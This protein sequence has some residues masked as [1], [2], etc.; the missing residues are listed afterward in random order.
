MRRALLF[1]WLFLFLT[2]PVF[3]EPSSLTVTAGAPTCQ[4]AWDARYAAKVGLPHVHSLYSNALTEKLDPDH[5]GSEQPLTLMTEATADW[6]GITDHDLKLDRGRWGILER[7]ASQFR[8][9]AKVLLLGIECTYFGAFDPRVNHVTLYGVEQLVGVPN[10]MAD[11]QGIAC[12][13]LE[14]L[15]LWL[16]TAKT[17]AVAIIAHPW[18]GDSHCNNMRPNLIGAG[19]E[20]TVGVEIGGGNDRRT[21]FSLNHGEQYFLQGLQNGLWL[22]P[23]FGH[24]NMTD[25]WLHKPHAKIPTVIWTDRSRPFSAQSL[26]EA[27]RAR[28]FYTRLSGQIIQFLGHGRTDWQPMGGVVALPQNQPLRL[29]FAITSQT[30]LTRLE[31]VQVGWGGTTITK[32]PLPTVTVAAHSLRKDFRYA[33]TIAITANSSLRCAYLRLWSG[34]QLE[35]VTAPIWITW[36]QAI[37]TAPGYGYPTE[38]AWIDRGGWWQVPTASVP[39]QWIIPAQSRCFVNIIRR[40]DWAQAVRLMIQTRPIWSRLIEDTE[41]LTIVNPTRT[42]FAINLESFHRPG[43]RGAWRRT[44]ECRMRQEAAAGSHTHHFGYEDG[45]GDI[46][47]DDI[48]VEIEISAWP[49]AAIRP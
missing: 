31:L 11:W 24:D 16:A 8:G 3:G 48:V 46:D 14:K 27:L 39:H 43:R 47:Y 28:R 15:F 26:L 12:P 17:Q 19:R 1:G 35:A 21:K 2:L 45:S 40:A 22:A 25:W 49:G 30:G 42:P 7:V 6:L 32:L 13:T 23:A 20:R 44:T 34:T 29:E 10:A 4:A 5:L 37:G 36:E 38:S 18:L 9:P 41:C 33:G